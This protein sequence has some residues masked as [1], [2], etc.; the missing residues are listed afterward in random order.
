MKRPLSIFLLAAACTTPTD[1][2]NV[3]R[4]SDVTTL[5]FNRIVA[6]ALAGNPDNRKMVEDEMV[7]Q[8]GPKGAAS[9]TI[10]TPQDTQNPKT[11]QAKLIAAGFDGAVT[12]K[13]LALSKEPITVKGNLPDGYER[14]SGYYGSRYD[15]SELQKVAS[16]ET[17]VFSVKDGKVLWSVTTRTL[18]AADVH[19]VIAS[20]AKTIRDRL[21]QD[22]LIN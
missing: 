10:L 13:L 4:S 12:M 5:S 7:R 3:K 18:D 14:L 1:I 16:V 6:I 11:A 21:R 8:I 22:Q 2:T 19:S 15:A 20:V 17:E 9:Y